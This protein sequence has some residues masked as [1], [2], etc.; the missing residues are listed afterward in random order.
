MKQALSLHDLE[1]AA[2]RRLPASIF[3]YV[4]GGSE[5]RRTVAANRAAFDGWRF[6][7]RPLVD[8]SRRSQAVTL[9]GKRYEAP[10]G[11]AP[12]GVAA[13]CHFDG[14]IALA[15]AARD[16]G[17][18]YV[19]S[20]ASTT[21]LERVS[22][23]NP[24]TWYQA[25]LPARTEVIGPLLDRVAAA[26]IGTLVVTVDVPIASVRENELRNGFTIPL[27]P[28]AQLLWGGLMRPHWLA[29]TFARTLVRQGIPH[30]E[31][32]TAER[33]GPIIQAAKGDH[34]AGRA[35]MTWN[36]IRWIRERWRG[37]LLLKG[38][39]RAGDAATAM[40]VGVDGVVV[41]NHGGRQLDGTLASL[42]ALPAM[43]A[44]A[45][46]LTLI[47]DGGIRRGT[48]VLKALALGASAVL[49]GRPVMYGLAAAGQAGAAHALA[50]LRREVDTDLALLG[51]PDV[52]AL[53]PDYLCRAATVLPASER[54]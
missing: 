52:A 54:P 53:G 38:L 33:G 28:S 4:S 25:Y 13:L 37:R 17:Q 36:E 39:L 49:V 51:C 50:L 34:R 15:G 9:F 18:P 42:D 47:L 35:A 6:V 24:D 41:S 43:A 3:G 12:M 5:D 22:E 46:G 2:R 19:L 30:F 32:F 48:D 29:A 40:A 7:P 45:P 26:G 21:P 16:A 11:I 44:A 10:V 14:D 31:N 8:V 27:R 20:A 23:A 1:Q